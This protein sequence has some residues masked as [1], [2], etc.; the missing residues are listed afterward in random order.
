MK[1]FKT[2]PSFEDAKKTGENSSSKSVT[3]KIDEDIQQV[4]TDEH[5]ARQA[6]QIT[7][8][9]PF[10]IAKQELSQEM[11][12]ANSLDIL[13]RPTPSADDMIEEIEEIEEEPEPETIDIKTQPMEHEIS[14]IPAPSQLQRNQQAF[15]KNGWREDSTSDDAKSSSETAPNLYGRP[16]QPIVIVLPTSKNGE[17]Q[18]LIL[19]Q[20]LINNSNSGQQVI[21]VINNQNSNSS[22]KNTPSS[23][24][25]ESSSSNNSNVNVIDLA[26][27]RAGIRTSQIEVKEEDSLVKADVQG[28]HAYPS[29]FSQVPVQERSHQCKFCHKRFARSDECKRHERIH[30]D[31]RPFSCTYCDRRFTRKD[32]LRTHTRCHTKEK[33]YKCPCCERSFARSD[34]RI[35]HLKIHVKRGETTMEEAKSKIN[36]ALREQTVHK[37]NHII[38]EEVKSESNIVPITNINFIQEDK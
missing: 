29:P 34:E 25:G 32:H 5:H 18:K 36:E 4:A 6:A 38:F 15:V 37:K 28:H 35:R 10:H 19:P 8:A 23:S 17:T 26:A 9:T 20:N 2:S 14:Y 27:T 13:L 1:T 30:T 31:T 12:A 7:G 22:S 33:P 11:S 21:Y 3:I 16:Q 24:F